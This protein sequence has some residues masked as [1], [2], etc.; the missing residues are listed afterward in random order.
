[1]KACSLAQW[2]FTT[3]FRCLAFTALLARF[4]AT[5]LAQNEAG[6]EAS[7][8]AALDLVEGQAF[9]LAADLEEECAYATVL[10]VFR[11]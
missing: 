5:A 4:R 11:C 2:L 1:L 6:L 9:R 3:F 7:S 10:G 8:S